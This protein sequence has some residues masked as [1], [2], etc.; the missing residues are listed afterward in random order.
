VMRPVTISIDARNEAGPLDRIWHCIG[1]CEINWTYTPIGRQILR[2]KKGSVCS[3]V[4]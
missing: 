1:Y 4:Q 3:D 2:E